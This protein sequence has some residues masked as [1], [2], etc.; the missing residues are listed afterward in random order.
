MELARRL[1]VPGRSR[2]TKMQLVEAIEKANDRST[3]RARRRTKR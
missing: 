3:D 1:D 2:M